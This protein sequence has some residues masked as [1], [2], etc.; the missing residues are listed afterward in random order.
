M[1]HSLFFQLTPFKQLPGFASTSDCRL[2]SGTTQ[3]RTEG[4]I[5][6]TW[7]KQTEHQIN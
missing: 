2:R 7:I 1:F 4:E 3:E 6:E 5:Q